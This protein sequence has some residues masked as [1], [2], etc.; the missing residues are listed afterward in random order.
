MQADRKVIADG[1]RYPPGDVI[2]ADA[3]VSAKSCSRTTTIGDTIP[4]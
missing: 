3:R 1:A 4:G 2:A